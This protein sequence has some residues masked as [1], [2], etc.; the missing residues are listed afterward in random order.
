MPAD[1]P[2]LVDRRAVLRFLA[3]T[4]VTG[5]AQAARALDEGLPPVRAI[6]RGPKLPL[7]RLLRQAGV[8]P[9][10]P[11][12]A[13]RWRSTSST[14]RPGRTTRSRSAW[15]TSHDGDRW[16]ELGE[17]RAWSWQQGCMLQW[18]PG[19]KTEVI[20]NDREGG[21]FVCHILDVADAARADAPRADLR[22]SSPDAPLGDRDRLPPAPRHAARLRLRRHPRPEPRRRSPPTTPGSGGST[23]APGEPSSCSRSARSPRS[24][25]STARAGGG[26]ALVQPPARLARRL[27]LRLPA[28]LA[29]PGGRATASPRA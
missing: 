7:V 26:Q 20:W 10:R 21:R 22:R 4:T 18:L 17:S 5:L 24:R 6:T 19:S 15:S 13:R 25:T 14:A 3:A 2:T 9:D 11:L 29:G 16:I 27:A 1:R 12:R 23:W 28:P 8:R